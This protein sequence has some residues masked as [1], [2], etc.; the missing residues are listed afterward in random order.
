M[1]SKQDRATARQIKALEL[2]Q[3]IAMAEI[4]SQEIRRKQEPRPEH[5]TRLVKLVVQLAVHVQ[6][7]QQQRER[8]EAEKEAPTN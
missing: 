1:T 7:L 4:L 3:I 6:D 5:L 2:E 8:E